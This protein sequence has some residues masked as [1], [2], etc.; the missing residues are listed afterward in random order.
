MEQLTSRSPF[1]PLCDSVILGAESGEKSALGRG[2]IT[3]NEHLRENAVYNVS[4]GKG[5]RLR[6]KVVNKNDLD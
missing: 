6:R 1:Q 3:P 4:Q 2:E 5:V